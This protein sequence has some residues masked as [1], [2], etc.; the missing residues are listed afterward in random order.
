MTQHNL[1]GPTLNI[2]LNHQLL[3]LHEPAHKT[4]LQFVRE[5]GLTGTKEGCASGD[6]GACTVMVGEP[7][8]GRDD[9]QVF[10]HAVDACITP[11][12][13]M[14]GRQIVTVEGLARGDELHPAQ[15]A[16][17]TCHGSQCGFCTPGFVMSLAALLA[18]S[19]QKAGDRDAVID[20]ISGNLCRCTGYRPIV[21][22]GL[23]ALQSTE[24]LSLATPEVREFLASGEPPPIARN[25][26]NTRNTRN[27]STDAQSQI[28]EGVMQP[29]NQEEL[30]QLISDHPT[31]RLIA[32]GT[33]LMLEVTQRF[34]HF[35][36][37]I[38]LTR[39]A[40]LTQLTETDAHIAIGAAVPYTRL[41]AYFSTRS[42]PTAQLLLRLGS[43]QIR[44]RGTIGGNLANGSPIAD[45]PPVLLVWDAVLELV[46]PDGG[47]RRVSVADFYT[48][49][50]QTVLAA[51]E[52]IARIILPKSALSC[53]HRFYKASK[54]IEDDIASVMGAFSFAGDVGKPDQIRIAFGGMAATP[55]RLYALEDF[56]TGKLVAGQAVAGQVVNQAVALLSSGLTP[57]TDVRASAAYRADL[58]AM[59]LQR[60][61]REFAGEH[62]PLISELDLYN[63]D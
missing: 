21:E 15:Q 20:S 41:Q 32:G 47:V 13:Q 31:A 12:G 59:M 33:D 5:Q 39:V 57:L 63:G 44:N 46:A 28:Q 19:T 2:A 6:C 8:A 9:H 56:L 49:Y 17:V 3:T 35:K 24:T 51:G 37:L 38:D 42:A 23:T 30:Q 10:Y 27:K 26:R 54:R 18:D 11:I 40:E 22:A 60:A 16:M 43:R 58:A 1:P 34:E 29:L 53:F 61:L 14:A 36:Q 25:A 7:L 62:L 45:M 50:R 52:Y 4:V 55:V 48:D